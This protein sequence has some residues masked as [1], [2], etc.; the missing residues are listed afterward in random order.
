VLGLPER[1]SMRAIKGRRRDLMARWHPDACQDQPEELCKEMAQRI[2]RAYEI[3]LSYCESYEYPFGEEELKRE[4][5]GGS[6]E[7]WWQERFG[8]D[9]LW[10]GTKK[11]GE[12]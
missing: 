9:P 5:D 11:K 4:K 2:N 10:S 12:G 3:V 7:R 8:D 1:A 6:Y